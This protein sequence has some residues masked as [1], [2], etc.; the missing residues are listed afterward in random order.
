MQGV[1]LKS[2]GSENVCKEPAHW[3]DTIAM[4]ITD[5]GKK[6]STPK[7]LAVALVNTPVSNTTILLLKP[8]LKASPPP[9][10][11]PIW[12]CRDSSH[13]WFCAAKYVFQT[14]ASSKMSGFIAAFDRRCH[15]VPG[16]KSKLVSSVVEHEVH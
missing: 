3:K 15:L 11:L 7:Q 13:S 12:H 6:D 16:N 10:P 9:P 8:D 4:H 14:Q 1:C 2:R 5:G